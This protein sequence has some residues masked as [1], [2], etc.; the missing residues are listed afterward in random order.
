LGPGTTIDN[1]Y[2]C[3]YEEQGDFVNQPYQIKLLKNGASLSRHGQVKDNPL[4][5]VKIIEIKKDA[6][7]IEV[8]YKITNTSD[9]KMSLWFASEFNFSLTNDETFEQLSQ[10]KAL[11]LKDRIMGLNISLEFTRPADIWR[12]PVKTISQSESGIEENYQSSCILPNWKFSLNADQVW[13]L[14][15]NI[16]I[17]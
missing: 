12:F 3:Q 7:D 5:V 14:G 15:I 13:G 8:V 4:S 11:S 10:D 9:E 6:L 1:F 17:S 16:H 2:R